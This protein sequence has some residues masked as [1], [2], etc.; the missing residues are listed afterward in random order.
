MVLANGPQSIFNLIAEW[1]Q[2]SQC[3]R[4]TLISIFL[5]TMLHLTSNTLPAGVDLIYRTQGSLQPCHVNSRPKFS[6][7]SLNELQRVVATTEDNLQVI[8]KSLNEVCEE[9]G[10]IPPSNLLTFFNTIFDYKG[11]LWVPEKIPDHQCLSLPLKKHTI[12]FS[13]SMQP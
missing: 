6:P 13:A 1:V 10:F 4:P 2:A 7:T 11:P 9:M 5:I 12:P 8:I 3:H